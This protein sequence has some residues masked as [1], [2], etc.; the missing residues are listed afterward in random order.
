M[1]AKKKKKR[2]SP[3][4]ISYSP[5]IDVSDRIEEKNGLSTSWAWALG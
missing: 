3:Y 5:N 1:T 2:H 4:G